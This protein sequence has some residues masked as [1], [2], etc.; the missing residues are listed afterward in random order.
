MDTLSGGQGIFLSFFEHV[1]FTSL[2]N[3]GYC[4][5]VDKC[6]DDEIMK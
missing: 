2:G 5:T 4:K 1:V 3:R 6:F